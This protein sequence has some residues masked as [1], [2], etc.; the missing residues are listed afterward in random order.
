MKGTRVSFQTDLAS[1]GE[2]DVIDFDPATEIVTV[3]EDSGE[4][5]RG[6]LDLIETV[7]TAE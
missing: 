5:W 1:Y 6:P 2:G 4:L 3:Q 7:E